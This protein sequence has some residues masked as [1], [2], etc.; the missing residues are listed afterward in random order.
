MGAVIAYELAQYLQSTGA[1]IPVKLYV[2]GARAPHFRLNHVP[3]PEPTREEFIENCG[4]WK[5]YRLRSWKTRSLSTR[6]FPNCAPMRVSIGAMSTARGPLV[7]MPIQA[8][9]GYRRPEYR[10]QTTRRLADAHEFGLW[11]PPISTAAISIWIHPVNASFLITSRTIWR[12]SAACSR[13]RDGCTLLA[14]STDRPTRRQF[15]AAA[16][17]LLAAPQ[18]VSGAQANSSLSL[19]LIGCGNRGMYVSGIFAKHEYLK[20]TAICDIYQDKLDKAGQSIRERK[21]TRT[22]TI[23][24]AFGC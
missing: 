18:I 19:G 2:S 22:I 9:G 14:M 5:G 15:A 17:F 7:P 6:F 21:H 3:G 24:L 23:V 16:P 10:I 11:C 4:V 8:F 20:V 12:L 13:K 1:A